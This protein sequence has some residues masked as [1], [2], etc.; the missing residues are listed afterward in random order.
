[1]KKSFSAVI[2]IMLV[3]MTVLQNVSFVSAVSVVPSS[4]TPDEPTAFPVS[5]D[6]T[7]KYKMEQE[8]KATVNDFE[9]MKEYASSCIRA[10][11]ETVDFSPYM[12]SQTDK[13]VLRYYI[14]MFLPESVFIVASEFSDNVLTI[15]YINRAVYGEEKWEEKFAEGLQ[16][17]YY[18]I[19][20]VYENPYLSELEKALILH[21][22]LGYITEYDFTYDLGSAHEAFM[23]H[24]SV[25]QGYA[26]AYKFLCDICGLKSYLISCR[27][28]GG[29]HVWNIVYIDG[30]PYHVD[31][32]WDSQMLGYVEHDY[33]LCSDEYFAYDHGSEFLS[34]MPEEANSKKYEG[35]F[36]S[37]ETY[38]Y[39]NGLFYYMEN[40]TLY[41]SKHP[42]DTNKTEEFVGSNYNLLTYD[43]GFFI[44]ATKYDLFIYDPINK[45]ITNIYSVDP[46]IYGHESTIGSMNFNYLYFNQFNNTLTFTIKPQSTSTSYENVT[47]DYAPVF[48]KTKNCGDGITWFLNPISNELIL[49]GEGM[50]TDYNSVTDVPWDEY[51]SRITAVRIGENVKK[52]GRNAFYNCP[53]IKTVIIDSP[54]IASNSTYGKN[55]ITG[56]DSVAVRSDIENVG[57]YITNKFTVSGTVI[58]EGND[59]TVYGKMINGDRIITAKCGDNAEYTYN[60]VTKTMKITGSGA[61][62]DGE[63]SGKRIR[64]NTERIE[65]SSEITK[66][67]SSAF[68]GFSK[69]EA[70]SIPKAVTEIGKR[71][72]YGANSLKALHIPASVTVIGT[73]AFRGCSG[74]EKITVD[75]NNNTFCSKG[76]CLIYKPEKT[77]IQGCSS[78]VIPDDGSVEYIGSFAFS[79]TYLDDFLIPG[80]VEIVYN[81]AF[82]SSKIKSLTVAEG[83]STIED[84]A[85][86]HCNELTHISLPGSL[87]SYL[88]RS[89][90]SGC[91]KLSYVNI[92]NGITQLPNYIFQDCVSLQTVVIPASIKTVGFYA[93]SECNNLKTV[94]YGG[95]C[96]Q[97][98]QIAISGSGNEA[99]QN[100]EIVFNYVPVIFGDCNGDGVTDGRDIVRLRKYLN[101]LDPVTGTA[102]VEITVGADCN[103][104]G[105]TDGKDLIRLR[106][107][108]IGNKTT[109]SRD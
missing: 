95:T 36:K 84:D 35:Y 109:N 41:S 91:E 69:I 22:R 16:T 34:R 87:G 103:G 17:V 23:F 68:S 8:L 62:Y 20:G 89:A 37:P 64:T 32:T 92:K 10:G 50:M 38:F 26:E 61:L 5:A 67:G 94:Y 86:I 7:D 6:I 105:K 3:F 71:A 81:M 56:S 43:G 74:L 40:N 53:N 72:F 79:G 45:N 29:P 49:S 59:Y 51:R 9:G 39:V 27:V 1:M 80:S 19:D 77:I 63:I 106:K 85:F 42:I 2:A 82:A 13:S 76:D 88:G 57:L 78:S 97:W 33:F 52:I 54:E 73:E 58:I 60:Y 28:P 66:I 83:V 15:Y 107:Y 100:A 65:I 99:L 31:V 18:L 24:S 44:F 21:D 104:D 55:M 102:D 101:T 48:Y 47:V 12:T 96:E 98:E 75:E 90:F 25:C 93:F 14:D 108:L 11:M 30:V 46:E 70:F 4:E